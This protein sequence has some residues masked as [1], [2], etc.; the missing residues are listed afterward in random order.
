MGKPMLVGE[1]KLVRAWKCLRCQFPGE[2]TLIVKINAETTK[3]ICRTPGCNNAEV[4]KHAAH[5]E[6]RPAAPPHAFEWKGG[7]HVSL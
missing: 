1:P 6:D 5:E 7:D 2:W 4:Y 3:V